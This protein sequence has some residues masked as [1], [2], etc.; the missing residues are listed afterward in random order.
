ML[1][2]CNTSGADFSW[3]RVFLEVIFVVIISLMVAERLRYEGKL[4]KQELDIEDRDFENE[5]SYQLKE[6]NISALNCV[7]KPP[8]FGLAIFDSLDQIAVFTSD[9]T[10]YFIPKEKLQACEL[11]ISYVPVVSTKPTTPAASRDTV[12]S[13]TDTIT[14]QS[15]SATLTITVDDVSTPFFK[16][17]FSDIKLAEKYTALIKIVLSKKI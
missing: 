11:T 8:G 2:G 9:R 4:K 16:L 7:V 1:H 6:R 5:F 12:D 10:M 14:E 13:T 15:Q 17:S 3:V